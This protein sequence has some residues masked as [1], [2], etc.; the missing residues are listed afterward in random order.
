MSYLEKVTPGPANN[1]VVVSGN[2]QT[3]VHP[4]LLG[5]LL[6]VTV[7][8]QYGNAVPG[9]SVTYTDNGAGGSFSANPVVTNSSGKASVLYTTPLTPGTVSITASVTGVSNAAPFTENVQ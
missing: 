8:D 4:S 2:N 6:T 3:A 9:A 1:I 5:K 7:T